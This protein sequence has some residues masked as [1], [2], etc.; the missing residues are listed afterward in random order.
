MKQITLLLLLSIATAHSFANFDLEIT[1]NSLDFRKKRLCK[2]WYVTRTFQEREGRKNRDNTKQGKGSIFTFGKD[3][4]FTMKDKSRSS[5]KPRVG[6]WKETGKNSFSIIFDELTLNFEIEKLTRDSLYIIATEEEK[7]DRKTHIIFS[8]EY[9]EPFKDKSVPISEYEEI[10]EVTSEAIE[11]EAIAI[12]HNHHHPEVKEPKTEWKE[13]TVY[14]LEKISKTWILTDCYINGKNLTE[15]YIGTS[16]KFGKDLSFQLIQFH[17]LNDIPSPGKWKYDEKTL[18]ITLDGIKKT[19]T[20]SQMT[21][22]KLK[23]RETGTSTFTVF[24]FKAQQ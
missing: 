14:S 24:T 1:A 8:S 10:T 23:L 6:T 15:E 21:D 22:N 9:V 7:N 19:Y 20:I 5:R 2:D 17:K 12:D 13:Q 16:Y 3:Y 11:E 4:S 18:E